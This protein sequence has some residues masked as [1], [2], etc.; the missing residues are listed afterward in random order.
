MSLKRSIPIRFNSNLIRL[1]VPSARL[2]SIAVAAI[3]LLLAIDGGAQASPLGMNLSSIVYYSSEQPFANLLNQAG[4]NTAY[5]GW[6]TSNNSTFDTNEEAYLQTDANGYVTSFTASPTPSGGQKFTY[7]QTIMNWGLGTAVG[8]THPYPAGQYTLAWTGQGTLVVGGD[9]S[10]GA[11][12]SGNVTVS[13]TTF[14]TTGTGTKV[15]TFQVNTPNQGIYL[16]LSSINA[17]DYPRGMYL[18][19]SS[20]YSAWQSAS[21]SSPAGYFQPAFLAMLQNFK[22]LRFMDWLNT[23]NAV[24]AVTWATAPT[25]SSG[26]SATLSSAWTLPSGSYNVAFTTGDVIPVT[27]TVGSTAATLSTALVGAGTASVNSYYST[28]ATTWATRAQPS[29]AFW[30]LQNGVPYEICIAL[31]N[32]IGARPWLNIPYDASNAFI[33]SLAT[34]TLANSS[35]API[36]ELGNELWNYGFQGMYWANTL[37]QALFGSSGYEQFQWALSWYGVKVANV[38]QQFYNVYGGSYANGVTISLGGQADWG[39]VSFTFDQ[40]LGIGGG[41]PWTTYG[42]TKPYQQTP[43]KIGAIHLAP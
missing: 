15:V 23:N 40:A 14:T 9:A 43:A 33:T 5:S 1:C 34:Y 32:Y 6:I 26:T 21:V 22:S 25:T 2:S 3:M 35:N 38:A 39:P 28:K 18:G 17:S 41:V 8:A 24:V 20:L 31:A 27:F 29:S 12:V 11:V 19:L 16:Q 37:D 4:S 42:G 30:G 13:G 36:I 10:S 7:V